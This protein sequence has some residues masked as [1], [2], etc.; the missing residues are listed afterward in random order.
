MV[1]NVLATGSIQSRKARRS[2]DGVRPKSRNAGTGRAKQLD[3]RHILIRLTY[4]VFT[5]L[6]TLAATGAD[7]QVY[8]PQTD[9]NFPK[10]RYADSLVSLNDR[11]MVRQAKMGLS[12]APVYVSGQPV[13]FC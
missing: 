2:L 9:L 3:W 13:G 1:F 5:T 7:A 8:V 11:C 4:L 6:A 12:H 10:I